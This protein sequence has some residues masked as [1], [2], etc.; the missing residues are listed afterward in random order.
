MDA[1]VMLGVFLVLVA[2]AGT[3][4]FPLADRA[5]PAD[6]TFTPVPEW[7]FLFFYQLLKYMSG[8]LTMRAPA[9]RTMRRISPSVIFGSNT[10]AMRWL[11]AGTAAEPSVRYAA[12]GS[13]FHATTVPRTPLAAS[14]AAIAKRIHGAA[15]R[16]V[17]AR[18]PAGAG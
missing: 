11:P 13:F 6:H 10:T 9:T 16:Q 14:C 17:D 12:T 4:E 7:Y 3:I 5:D 2:L 1:V 18:R 15:R 8:P